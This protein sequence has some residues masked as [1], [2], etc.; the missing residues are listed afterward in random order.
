[1]DLNDAPAGNRTRGP[2]MGMLDFATKPLALAP[3]PNN[4]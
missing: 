1:M 3:T 2:T 4:I